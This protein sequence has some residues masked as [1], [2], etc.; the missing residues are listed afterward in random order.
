MRAANEKATIQYDA[1]DALII[2]SRLS[3]SFTSIVNKHATVLLF[4]IR[5]HLPFGECVLLVLLF[6]FSCVEIAIGDAY[7]VLFDFL[8]TSS[9]SFAA[10]VL[11]FLICSLEKYAVNA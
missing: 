6:F 3:T 4:F 5:L 10:S 9:I 8:S 2:C 1:D 11:L 7:C